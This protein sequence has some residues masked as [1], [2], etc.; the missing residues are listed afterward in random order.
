L[1]PAHAAHIRRVAGLYISL[2]YSPGPAPAELPREIKA[3][4]RA[5]RV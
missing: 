2:R 4:R 5:A 3:F 1:L